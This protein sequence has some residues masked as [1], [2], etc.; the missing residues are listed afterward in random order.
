[1]KAVVP[2]QLSPVHDPRSKPTMSSRQYLFTK[3]IS[4]GLGVNVHA[5]SRE[6]APL[7][8]PRQ[9]GAGSRLLAVVGGNSPIV[10][11][12]IYSLIAVV[13]APLDHQKQSNEE[14]CP[15]HTRRREVLLLHT[16]LHA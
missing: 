6:G 12:R 1:M 7:L 14:R 15:H 5:M 2:T 9:S 4:V 10:G 3:I 13:C 16:Q 11:D 8:A